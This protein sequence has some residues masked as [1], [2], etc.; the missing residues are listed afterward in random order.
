MLM[1]GQI[2]R[3]EFNQFLLEA[4][5]ST[6][7][8]DKLYEIMNREPDEFLAFSMFKRGLISE[9]AMK[10]CFRIRGYDAVWDKALYQ[11]LHRVP[12][13]RELIMVSD[14]V[15]LPDI[16][17][18]EVLRQNGYTESTVNYVVPAIRMRPLRE[19][20]RS[21]V[22]RYL[23][24]FQI[25]R[26]D[27]DA[28]EKNLKALNLLPKEVELNMTWA[29]LRYA[30][31]LLDEEIEVLE[32]RVQYGDPEMQDPDA[33]F[34]ALVTLGIAEEKANLMA[35]LWYYKYVYVPT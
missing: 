35:E 26:I 25:G 32:A 33:V 2:G 8:Q 15:Q 22:G 34:S 20:I 29:D 1:E 27:R 16:Y 10:Q 30:D 11:A 28:L 21:V 4:G 7:Y 19:E 12:T 23:W 31:E 14:F 24:E 17:V 5:W 3:A 9:S 18:S 13:L 6:K